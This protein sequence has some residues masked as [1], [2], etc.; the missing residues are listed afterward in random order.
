MEYN[1]VFFDFSRDY[2]RIARWELE[3]L[4]NCRVR[5]RRISEGSK[6]KKL[7]YRLHISERLNRYITLPFQS[8]WNPAL[9]GKLDFP[10]DKPICFLFTMGFM[11]LYQMDTFRYLRKTYPGCKL[12]LLLRDRVA[13]AESLSRHFNL[14]KAKPTFDYIYTTSTIEAE[15]FG[16]RQISTMCSAYPVQTG[17]EDKKSDVIF[18]GVVKDRLD[19][20]RRAYERFT[21]AGL[22][23]D[24]L[25]VSKTPIEGLP[26]GLTVQQTGISYTQML[27]RTVN[28]RCILEVTQK[29]TDAMT[30]RCLEALCYNKKLISDNFR[31]KEL[32]YY[33]P[34][35]M[36][37]FSDIDQVDPA[38]IR[39]E[40]AV[41]YG[42]QGDFSPVRM[43]ETIERDL[44]DGQKGERAL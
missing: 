21:A 34:R 19:T 8:I 30:S 10:E 27:Q 7:L 24:F 42:Y 22:V 40:T 12:V 33:D 4:P 44:L 1:Y 41:D 36:C 23:C 14:E 39:E 6:L 9:I 17:P 26:E 28:S 20:V 37:L 29:G 43:L 15:K 11:F 35:Y 16:L 5:E 2:Y 32:K 25:L 38:F 31:L 18:V 3:Q 13:V